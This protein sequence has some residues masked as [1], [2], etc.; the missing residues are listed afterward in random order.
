M[1]EED[2]SKFEPSLGAV[3]LGG[4]NELGKNM[5]VFEAISGRQEGESEYIVVDAGTLYPGYEQPSVDYIMPDFKYILDKTDRIRALFLTSAHEA[6][7]GCAAQVIQKCSIKK[8]YGSSLALELTK[9]R[10]GEEAVAKIEW[11]P[12]EPRKEINEG[13]FK[14]IP[15]RLTSSSS[16]SY[17]VAIEAFDN[18]VFYTGTYKIDQ[19]AYDGLKTDLAGITEYSM[20][21]TE[22]GKII[23]LYIGDSANVEI[24]GYSKSEKTLY[25]KLKA[26]FENEE[27][28]I[29]FNTYNANT[30]RMQMVLDLAEKT[31]R[32]VA[33]LNKDVKQVY[34]AAREAGI[35]KHKEGTVISLREIDDLK[36]KEILVMSSAPEGDALKELVLLATDEDLEFQLKEGDAVVNS[37]DPPPGTI[38]V[39]AQACDQ[40]F[41][42]KVKIIGGRNA[43]VHAESNALTEEMKFMFNL[44][45]PKAFVPA[46]GDT[47]QLVRHAKLAVDTGFDPASIFMLDNGD[48]F[49][50]SKGKGFQIVGK[51]PVGEVMFNHLQDIDIDDKIVKERETLS[52]EGVVTIAF[53]LDKKGKIISGPVFSAKACT[54]SKNK[55]WRAFCMIHTQDIV[56]NVHQ[57]SL[58][59]PAAGNED[60]QKIVHEHMAALIRTQIGKKPSISVIVNRI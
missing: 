5:W 6:H 57:I 46:V 25:S 24:E 44:L 56:D 1:T 48:V 39:M 27:G 3:A 13:E 34:Y 45:R 51:A 22:D 26:I 15:F 2:N 41:L 14:I 53:S 10:L 47:R 52:M 29:I 23:D 12:F 17:A 4:M 59:K 50:L 20:G 8:V 28:R 18:K 36:D 19:T 31:G 9:L 42:K 55:E 32:K 33:L 38:R 11:H 43:G 60:Y 58:D 7:A 54:F 30:I 37:G 16:E 35:F 40:F 21:D 49:D